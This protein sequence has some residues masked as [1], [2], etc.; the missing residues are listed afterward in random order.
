MKKSRL[1]YILS[2]ERR[3]ASRLNTSSGYRLDMAERLIDYPDEF[4]KKFFSTLDHEDFIVYPKNDLVNELKSLLSELNKTSVQS[5]LI[6]SGSD[7]LIKNCLHSL[8]NEDD[9][10]MIC[11][12]SFPMYKIYATMFSLN[13]QEVGFQDKPIFNLD[14]IVN[15]IDSSTKMVILSNPNSPYGDLKSLEDI[16]VLLKILQS[17]NIYL[18]LDEAYI[19]FGGNSIVSLISKYDRLIVLRT[20]SKA[21][22]AAGARVGYCISNEKTIN[23]IEK[24]QLTYPVSN[25]SLK[26]AIF[27]CKNKSIVDEYAKSTIDERDSLIKKLRNIGYDVIDSSNNSIHLHDGFNNE[28]P[29]S[30]L[31]KYKV[32]FKTGSTASTP[33]EIPG[34]NRT[35][36]IRISVGKGILKTDYIKELLN[37]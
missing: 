20:F 34:D 19:D 21:W 18:L 15:K 4:I 9:S 32:S 13:I 25:V 31:N 22:G 26:F 28:R 8:C 16:E 29:V 7:A 3:Q 36:W 23:Q 33:L 6:D 37:E 35:D 1:E 27:L 11:S 12:P 24:V 2:I 17:K 14:N 30:I 10:I 5:L